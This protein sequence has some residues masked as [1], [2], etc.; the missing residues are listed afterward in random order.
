M[1][2]I[3]L[4]TTVFVF[5][6][7]EK[8]SPTYETRGLAASEL[9]YNVFEYPG[10]FVLN[11]ETPVYTVEIEYKIL[12]K[13]AL[14]FSIQCQQGDDEPGKF[15]DG[16][17]ALASFQK[18][19]GFEHFYIDFTPP[20]SAN[21]FFSYR[22]APLGVEVLN[23]GIRAACPQLEFRYGDFQG[24]LL[25][26]PDSAEILVNGAQVEIRR[27]TEPVVEGTYRLNSTDSKEQCDG[28]NFVIRANLG[29]REFLPSADFQCTRG[30][31]AGYSQFG[32]GDLRQ[33]EPGR[34]YYVLVPGRPRLE[35]IQWI[36]ERCGACFDIRDDD[37]Q[38]IGFEYD[39]TLP[40]LVTNVGGKRMYFEWETADLF[41]EA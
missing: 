36:R 17:F 10:R 40:S 22:Y 8:P 15:T 3:T 26:S 23:E 5:C 11:Y 30:E 32:Y 14:Y 13:G 20:E 39:S 1:L 29:F 7:G 19:P 27:Y 33:D 2:A 21:T 4:L 12:Y 18:S 37:M 16:P 41:P 24:F 9:T 35:W 25:T 6:V 28:A 38:R 31:G 34:P